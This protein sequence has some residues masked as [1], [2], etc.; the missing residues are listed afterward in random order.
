[1]ILEEIIHNL[2][3]MWLQIHNDLFKAAKG[4]KAAAQ[5]VRVASI[6]L[7]KMLKE[8]RKESVRS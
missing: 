5:R 8:F 2:V 1:M 3:D 4:N 6:H 7:E